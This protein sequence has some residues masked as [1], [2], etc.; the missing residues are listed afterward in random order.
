LANNCSIKELHID[1][2][3]EEL[4][5]EKGIIS[6]EEYAMMPFDISFIESGETIVGSFDYRCTLNRDKESD[7]KVVDKQAGP[8]KEE[9]IDIMFQNVSSESIFL[10]EFIS[11]LL[12]ICHVICRFWESKIGQ[13]TKTR[14]RQ[15]WWGSTFARCIIGWTTTLVD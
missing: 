13:V 2:I 8:T 12:N 9:T 3:C 4:K 11:D 5:K 6:K 1:K 15:M 10:S 14:K 7:I